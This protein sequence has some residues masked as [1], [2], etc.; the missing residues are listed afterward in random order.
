MSLIL[1]TKCVDSLGI[2]K[3]C[4]LCLDKYLFLT[5]I[6]FSF[7]GQLLLGCV[8]ILT[9]AILTLL[10]LNKTT[11]FKLW[12]MKDTQH[13]LHTQKQTR[14]K[15]WCT[16]ISTEVELHSKQLQLLRGSPPR[17]VLEEIC[18]CCPLISILIWIAGNFMCRTD[19]CT[20]MTWTLYACLWLASDG[21]L[22]W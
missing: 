19:F 3:Q 17:T 7:T 9:A 18:V 14:E 10:C 21:A 8:R 16:K 22:L 15:E 6:I 11:T 5:C 1:H 12:R 2:A 13:I 20:M 4:C